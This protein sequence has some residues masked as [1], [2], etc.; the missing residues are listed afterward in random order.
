MKS[1]EEA[2]AVAEQ[3]KD[4]FYVMAFIFQYWLG[5]LAIQASTEY[6]EKKEPKD[7]ALQS[8]QAWQGYQELFP[9]SEGFQ[10]KLNCMFRFARAG[11]SPANLMR[12]AMGAIAAEHRCT[13]DY[14]GPKTVQDANQE[15]AANELARRT[16]V[17]LCDWLDARVHLRTHRKWY[18]VPACFD[19]DPEM[20]WLAMLGYTQRHLAKLDGAGMTQWMVDFSRAAAAYKDS[21][22]WTMVGKAMSAEP[23]RAW[24]YPGVDTLVIAF[25]PL[26][27]AHNWTYRDLLHV[28]RPALKRPEAY[29]CQRE[30]D[31]AT[32]CVNVLG[33]RKKGKGVSAKDGYPAG[34]D[35]ALALCPALKGNGANG[36]ETSQPQDSR[37]PAED[38]PSV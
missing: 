20:R 7:R 31:F 5:C 35:V 11:K 33:L 30:Q 4:P 17:R 16:I 10:Y 25:W 36:K 6:A 18:H 37:A 13:G 3:R 9:R 14:F 19:P 2:V 24:L 28:I 22:K 29:P 34:Y 1:F 21:H 8:G 27:K 15:E 12:A 26:V 23:D 32:Y 38:G